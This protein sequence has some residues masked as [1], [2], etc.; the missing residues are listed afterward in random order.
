VAAKQ[1]KKKNFE[2]R[3][4]VIIRIFGFFHIKQ[5]KKDKDHTATLCTLGDSGS[6]EATA[7]R[8]QV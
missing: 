5:T 2:P 8:L 4:G 7:G 1:K 3:S 6:P